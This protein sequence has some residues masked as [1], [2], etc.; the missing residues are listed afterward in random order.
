MRQAVKL[1]TVMGGAAAE[2][3]WYASGG[4]PGCIAAYQAV[5]AASLAASYVNLV[6]PGT[7]DLTEVAAPTWTSARGWI[8][9]G[10]QTLE[11]PVEL[12]LGGSVVMRM[13]CSTTTFRGYNLGTS[14][15]SRVVYMASADWGGKLYNNQ[16]AVSVAGRQAT[17]TMAICGQKCYS[18]GSL[19]G[20]C[21]NPRL[22]VSIIALLCKK[23]ATG[24][25][26]Y[27]TG[28][29][30]AVAMYSGDVSAY[31]PAIHAAMMALA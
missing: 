28:D 26:A 7:G 15:A 29:L 14:V 5:G 11:S 10:G 24:Y 9:A 3:P 20:E 31:M 8:A 25:D 30:M 18:D 12:P 2:V 4:A 23:T 17:G 19:V 22:V 13:V 16:N 1:L 6:T 27:Y 21:A